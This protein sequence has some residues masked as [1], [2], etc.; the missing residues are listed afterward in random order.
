MTFEHRE[1]PQ[2]KTEGLPTGGQT[3]YH[4]TQ[5]GSGFDPTG[6]VV[7]VPGA[8]L[9][10]SLAPRAPEAGHEPQSP[11]E[12]RQAPS[13]GGLAGSPTLWL[14]YEDA[15]GDCECCGGFE[16]ECPCAMGECDVCA[17]DEDAEASADEDEEDDW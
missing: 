8:I 12:G 17:E 7:V 16:S 13:S 15:E 5:L 3:N 14:P 1:G 6:V 10:A 4:T 9:P 11:R 2:P